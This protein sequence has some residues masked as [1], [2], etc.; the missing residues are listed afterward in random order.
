M[1]KSELIVDI[2]VEVNFGPQL[3]LLRWL[4]KALKPCRLHVR[5]D[6]EFSRGYLIAQKQ[7][8]DSLRRKLK[9]MLKAMEDVPTPK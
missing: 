5:M 3:D 6:N 9:K 1:T 7:L 8:R 2:E 4:D